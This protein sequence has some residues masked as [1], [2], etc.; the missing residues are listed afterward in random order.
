M[1]PGEASQRVKTEEMVKSMSSGVVKSTG[2]CIPDPP[3]LAMETLNKSQY[4][5]CKMG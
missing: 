3:L 4:P 5:I 2:L 1:Q